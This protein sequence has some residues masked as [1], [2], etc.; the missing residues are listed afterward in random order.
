MT[1]PIH[2]FHTADWQIGKQFGNIPGD[3]AAMVR[4]Q[5]LKTVE[6]IAGLA[7]ARQVDAVLVAGDVFEDNGVSDETLRRTI[8]AMS[9]YSGNWVL[10]PGNHDAVLA[11][12]AWS[13]LER[14]GLISE[15]IHLALNAEP[16]LLCN[17]RLAVLPAPLQR[18]HETRDLTAAF[19][20]MA[21]PEGAIRVGL[22]HG[23]VKNR[24]PERSEAFNEIADDRAETARLDYLALGDWHGTLEIAP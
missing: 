14:L 1:Q 5:R 24:L 20:Q 15:N 19:D 16:I 8:N 9:A 23:S 7:Q 13:R 2:L 21:T 6:K 4:Q 3:A 17:E 11:E 12:S 18:R 22:A 10:L